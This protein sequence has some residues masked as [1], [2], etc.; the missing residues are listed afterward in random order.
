MFNIPLGHFGAVY[1]M[2][3]SELQANNFDNKSGLYNSIP[4]GRTRQL[5]ILVKL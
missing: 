1:Y 5:L 2:A 3:M 4:G